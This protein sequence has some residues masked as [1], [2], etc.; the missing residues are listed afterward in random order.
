MPEQRRSRRVPWLQMRG[1][2][3]AA[4]GFDIQA[5]VR[6]RVMRGCLVLTV[7]EP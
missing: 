6:V 5:P 4:A 2:W 7:E 3:L 1:D